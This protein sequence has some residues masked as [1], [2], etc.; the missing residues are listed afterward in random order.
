MKVFEG[1]ILLGRSVTWEYFDN[2][3]LHGSGYNSF[4]LLECVFINHP[5]CVAIVNLCFY[6]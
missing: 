2:F 1:S 3:M 6:T 5:A 4:I